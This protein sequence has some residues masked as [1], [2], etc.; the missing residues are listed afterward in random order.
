[1][2]SLR[3]EYLQC[4]RLR[5]K[6]DQR[7]LKRKTY[8]DWS[9]QKYKQNT[10]EIR[11]RSGNVAGYAGYHFMR[12]NRSPWKACP[13]CNFFVVVS[14]IIPRYRDCPVIRPVHHIDVSGSYWHRFNPERSERPCPS[15]SAFHSKLHV[16][17]SHLFCHAHWHVHLFLYR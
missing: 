1:M 2:Q 7:K 16:W 11:N 15:C 9:E 12:S 14:V 3:D 6:T 4:Q 13:F 8:F 10:S 17:L 5:H